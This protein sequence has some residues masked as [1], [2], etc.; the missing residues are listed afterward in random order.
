[1]QK[2]KFLL[3]ENN[4]MKC[5]VY[6]TVYTIFIHISFCL[7]R[8]SAISHRNAFC[9]GILKSTES[10]I[11]INLKHSPKLLRRKANNFKI[12]VLYS[13]MLCTYTH[14]TESKNIYYRLC[15]HSLAG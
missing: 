14:C 10:E 11:I 8:F 5:I 9:G 7:R 13:A 15:M 12:K 4:W 1:M 3:L 2:L 6:S